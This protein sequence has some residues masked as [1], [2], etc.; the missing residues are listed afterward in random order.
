MALVNPLGDKKKK[1]E[2]TNSTNTSSAPVGAKSASALAGLKKAQETVTA[3][4]SIDEIAKEVIRGDWGN[5]Q[6][7]IDRLSAAG[8]NYSEV[9]ARVNQLMSGSAPA[10]AAPTKKSIDEIAKEVIRGDW[11]NGQD[12]INRLSAA[13]YNYNEV[14]ARVNQLMGGS[15]PA[16]AAPAKKSID[17]IAKEVIRGQ[18]GNGQERVDRLTAAGYSYSEVQA[19][20][21]QL[22]K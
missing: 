12:R 2:T 1:E 7:R 14:Q 3:K 21:N 16:Q 8:Y 4:K 22:L 20:V 17:E 5:G 15:A 13:G 6:D 10:Q 19:R 11:G 18:W 9:Q